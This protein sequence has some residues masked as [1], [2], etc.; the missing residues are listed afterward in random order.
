MD[1][2]IC[3]VDLNTLEFTNSQDSF[4]G[5]IWSMA[6]SESSQAVAIGCEDGAVRIMSLDGGVSYLRTLQTLQERV[7]SLVWD[8]NKDHLFSGGSDGTIC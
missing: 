8:E 6:L 1:G 5:P 2:T 3:E 7:L 4:G